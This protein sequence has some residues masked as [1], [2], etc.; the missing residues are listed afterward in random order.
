M[1]RGR[2]TYL[3]LTIL[4]VVLLTSLCA[5]N[6]RLLKDADDDSYDKYE[7]QKCDASN[8]GKY[9]D[10]SCQERCDDE[11][12]CVAYVEYSDMCKMYAECPLVDAD[13][14]DVAY[15]K[16]DS[17]SSEEYEKYE[18]QKCDAN[19]IGKYT[20]GSCQERCDDEDSCVAYVEYSDMCKIYAECP[21]VDADDSDVAYVKT[22]SSPQEEYGKYEG[23]KCDDS[24]IGKYTDGSCQ[25]RCDD[26]DSCV[27]YVEYS[28]MCK[29]YAE[30]PLVDAD[31]SDVAYV[32]IESSPSEEYEKYEGQKCDASNIG[33]YT[34]GSCQERCDDEDSCVAYVEYSDMCKM[35]AECPLVDADDSDVAYVKTDNSPSDDDSYDKYEGQKCDASN[36]GKYTDGS[37]Q[38]RCDDEDS[39]V[40]YVEYSDMC[41]M[42][43][44]CPLVDA[45][46]SDVAYV[47][48]E[49]SPS[50]EYEKYEGQKCDASNIG[51]YTDGSC[52]ERCDDEDSCEAYVEYSDMCKM[53]AECPLVDAD[54]SDVAY[55][56]TDSSP[57]DE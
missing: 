45:D 11:D 12:S 35:Y 42:Y 38:E 43:A 29:M 25:E 40:A 39:C 34:D 20:D 47:K 1:Q 44:E 49:S 33:K 15:V 23:Q 10:G 52:Q 46:D 17:S 53:Y 32:K 31:D 30:C 7:G 19:N 14:S 3:Q 21:L 57:S 48:I 51:K 8:I 28:D 50:E 18:G 16:T 54:G 27:A 55:V 4:P 37:C 2:R 24:N 26:E 41:K 13:G 9:T 5:V 22:D 56:K 6:A 36:I